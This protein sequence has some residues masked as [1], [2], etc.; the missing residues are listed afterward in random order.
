MISDENLISI[1]EAELNKFFIEQK[2]ITVPLDFNFKIDDGKIEKW[3]ENY[4]KV[5][6]QAVAEINKEKEENEQVF[7]Q[8]ITVDTAVA[9]T[10]E[11]VI[12]KA[13]D[14]LQTYSELLDAINKKLKEKGTLEGTAYEG[15]SVKKLEAQIE[16]NK[17][18]LDFFGAP[19]TKGK[20]KGK[21]D[22]EERF[23][24]QLAL[25]KTLRQE[26]IKLEKVYGETE[27][28]SK[29][30]EHYKS[31]F[32]EIF[33]GTGINWD[34]I[35]NVNEEGYVNALG[36]LRGLA[37][38]AGKAA[39]D[40]FEK[41]LSG[42][43][44]DVGIKNQE[45]AN[46]KKVKDLEKF[47]EDYQLSLDLEKLGFSKE[48]MKDIFGFDYI[49]LG[50]LR[51]KF[52]EQRNLFIGQGS[53]LEGEYEKIGKRLN[54]LE[55]YSVKE[56]AKKYIKYLL[57]SQREAVKIKTEEAADIAA[58]NKL[59]TDKVY[60]DTE[61]A[62]IIK[63][64]KSETQKELDKI[65]WEDFKGTDM[66]SMMFE[67]LEHY[68]TIA[69]NGLKGRI[70]DLKQSLSHLPA[71]E[72]KEIVSQLEKIEEITT[73]RRPME[74]IA[75]QKEIIERKGLSR[76]DAETKL[77]ERGAEV[78]NL[79][80]EI[81]SLTTI[82]NLQATNTELTE[83]Q[84]TQ[85]QSITGEQYSQTANLQKQIDDKTKLLTNA[86][87]EVKTAKEAA[88]AYADLDDARGKALGKISQI[89]ESVQKASQS[90]LG[91]MEALGVATDS[92]A[93][94]QAEAVDG[95][96]T[97][98]LQAVQFHSQM[99]SVGYASNMAL[100]VIGWIAMGIQAL[101]SAISAITKIH[102][103][104]LDN[105]IQKYADN[106][107]KLQKEFEALNESI[108]AAYDTSQ[109]KRA[110]A[111][112]KQYTQQMINS[113]QQ[114]ILLEEQKKK[115]DKDKIEEYKESIAEQQ[116]ALEDLENQMLESMGGVTDYRSKTE[117]FVNS[118]IEAYKNVGDGLGGLQ[119]NFTEFFDNIISQQATMKVTE[120]FLEPFYKNLNTYLDDY[121]LS[122]NEM[123][124]LRQQAEKI[125]PELSNYLEE[126]WNI[127]G[128]SM[129]ENGGS[130]SGLQQGIQG[131]TEDTAQILASYLNSIRFFVSDNNNIMK[132]LRDYIISNDD[133]I[134]PMLAQMRIIAKQ[135]ASIS[136]LLNSVT[137]TN[138]DGAGQRGIRVYMP[139]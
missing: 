18:I 45:K 29:I 77:V 122:K 37:Q 19:Y 106:V 82:Q 132:Q 41:E 85:Y 10:R 71:S 114:M 54:K 131:M 7:F 56:R 60:T 86:K 48:Q 50:G 76:K 39:E 109:L 115:T 3:Q 16:M 12:K 111:D 40:A 127:L 91:L 46:E 13:Q 133:A 14:D 26:F 116:K 125:A 120:K 136:E 124:S 88:K 105:E 36:E 78:F 100:G 64:I 137:A 24:R 117:D 32:D 1:L 112:A 126:L 89:L 15:E 6:G 63:G 79:Q 94:A 57:K 55:S 62:K 92:V 75:S 135:T 72:M 130:L 34:F 31:A 59:V 73:T 4:N 119:D 11:N 33:E 108:D 128:G 70:E 104:K 98:T 81:D 66:Y 17:K 27:A 51:T 110:A 95:M 35:F 5:I 69:L 52:D 30:K 138:S 102:D 47:F 113:Y 107:E 99:V 58:I 74:A 25:I 38:K 43:T 65:I 53:W 96:I 83:E 20:K 44:V 2:V 21:D 121:E 28:T 84:K 123:D 67:D 90:A 103:A 101:T 68:G 129:G 118:W 22:T 8:E 87:N 9:N 139:A 23:K 49:D 42:A 97:L 134:N 93:Y 80:Q 61:G